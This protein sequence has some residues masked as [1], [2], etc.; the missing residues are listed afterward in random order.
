MTR[1][2]NGR[3]RQFTKRD[4]DALPP[5]RHFDPVIT[6]FGVDVSPAGKRT[7]FCRYWQGGRRRF[8]KV[9]ALGEI[10]VEQAREQAQRIRGAAVLGMEPRAELGLERA[11]SD[12]PTPT[13]KAWR[14]S[15]LEELEGRRKGLPMIAYHLGKC[16]RAWEPRKLA[17][18]TERD[19][20]AVLASRR[21]AP[22]SANRWLATL[23]AMF[24]LAKRR[25]LIDV[26]PCENVE[27]FPENAPR[28]RTLN[29]EELGRLRDAI[30]AEPDP[31]VRAAIRL[32][33]ETGC[34][35]GETLKARWEDLDL[36]AGL[37]RLPSPKAGRPQ[38][39]FLHPVTVEWLSALP[40]GGSYVILGRDP[41]KPR[42]DFKGAWR[43]IRTAA[44]LDT[45][46]RTHDLRRTVGMLVAR[47][48]GLHLASRVL[49]HSDVR[50]TAKVYAPLDEKEIRG[51]V[52]GLLPAMTGEA[53]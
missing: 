52:A 21:K 35:I 17:E 7:F 44:G 9:G 6:G 1:D 18:I 38:T 28:S 25:R 43:R 27:F 31:Y 48:A 13:F 4:I 16:P 45:D 30:L 3:P 34:R 42:C 2:S 53:K 24:G 22:I 49:R 33:M 26:N 10:T 14:K 29:P 32:Q 12:D 46:T 51:A 37:W 8:V 36:E 5:G 40:R 11:K 23:S 15:Y 39:V 47:S 50:M 19:V 41:E 20:A